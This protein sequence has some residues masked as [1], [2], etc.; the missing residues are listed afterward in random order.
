MERLAPDEP[1]MVEDI[2]T[3]ISKNVNAE[4][5]AEAPGIWIL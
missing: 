5:E 2:W 3:E 1:D 4:L